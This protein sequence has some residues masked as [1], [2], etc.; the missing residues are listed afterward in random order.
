[1][2]LVIT[3]FLPATNA[4]MKVRF[5]GIKC[6][7]FNETAASLRCS[8]KA[9]SR[10]IVALNMVQTRKI[11]IKRPIQVVLTFP[12]LYSIKIMSFE[13]QNQRQLPLRNNL[14]RSI[15]LRVRWVQRSGWIAEEQR[16]CGDYS[17]AFERER[18]AICSA[19]STTS[20]KSKCLKM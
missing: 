3:V 15:Q 16:N 1:M 12:V 18:S 20:S 7:S 2:F 9:Y 10:T 6:T 19:M 11:P 5:R 13:V 17:G 14:S 4:G 8:L